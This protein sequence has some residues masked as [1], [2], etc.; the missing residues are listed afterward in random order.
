MFYYHVSP[1][2][3]RKS[4]N[5][6]GILPQNG[7]RAKRFG[8][9]QS[10]V[11]FTKTIHH[12]YDLTNILMFNTHPDFLNGVDIWRIYYSDDSNIC[13]DEKYQNGF[14]CFE[15]PIFQRLINSSKYPCF[16]KKAV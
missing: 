11:F 8:H 6:N 13:I 1:K 7:E 2:K 15:K 12:A 9:Q 4:I 10:S 14:Y 5:L 3:F 16:S